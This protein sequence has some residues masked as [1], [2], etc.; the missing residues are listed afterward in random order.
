MLI[1]AW[2]LILLLILLVVAIFHALAADVLPWAF[3]LGVLL[4]IGCWMFALGLA[5]LK[6]WSVSYLEKR[7]T[8]RPPQK[9]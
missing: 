4:G 3:S 6:F 2:W 9:E 1:R 8:A 7:G 5:Q